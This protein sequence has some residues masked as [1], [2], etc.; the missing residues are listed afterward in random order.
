M[1]AAKYIVVDASHHNS[2]GKLFATALAVK[3]AHIRFTHLR[4]LAVCMPRTH[5][6][7]LNRSSVYRRGM[8]ARPLSISLSL[9]TSI[10]LF[11]SQQSKKKSKIYDKHNF[12]LHSTSVHINLNEIL[13]SVYIHYTHTHSY[14]SRIV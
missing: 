10:L 4:Q 14:S 3:S 12:L 13:A 2:N 6:K 11:L 7:L 5:I 1:C 8:C 9:S